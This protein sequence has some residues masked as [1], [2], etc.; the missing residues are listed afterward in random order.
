MQNSIPGPQDH[1]SQKQQL[2]HCARLRETSF[3]KE[4]WP[5]MTQICKALLAAV[6]T[7]QEGGKESA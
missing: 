2:N 6:A 4:K 1:M 7:R 5:R 3:W